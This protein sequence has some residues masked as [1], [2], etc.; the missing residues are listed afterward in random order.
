LTEDPATKQW[1]VEQAGGD[2]AKKNRRLLTATLAADYL[3]AQ[4]AI[5]SGA[6]PNCTNRFGQTPL[7]TIAKFKQLD[8]KTKMELWQPL[9]FD[10]LEVAR[11]L[12][13]KGADADYQT[14][15]GYSALMHAASNDQVGF[16]RLLLARGANPNLATA[17]GF[18]ALHLASGQHKIKAMEILLQVRVMH[19]L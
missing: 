8:P 7:I 4:Q 3:S 13:E 5:E 1:L 2:I 12:L 18:S 16:M 14:D 15:D 9:S 10:H 6:Q 17:R 19:V 11:L